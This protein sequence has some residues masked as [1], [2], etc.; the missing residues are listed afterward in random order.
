MCFIYLISVS[1]TMIIFLCLDLPKLQT[2]AFHN[3]D[4]LR[5]SCNDDRKVMINGRCSYDN[6]LIMKSR[7]VETNIILYIDLPS[8]T[9]IQCEENCRSIHSNMGYV[10]LEST[11]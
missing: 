10:I 6:T 5:G 8:L 11:E 7:L 3:T 2:I 1:I 9:S 4:G